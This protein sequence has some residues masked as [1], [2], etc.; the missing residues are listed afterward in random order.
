[1]VVQRPHMAQGRDA[2][3]VFFVH[4]GQWHTVGKTIFNMNPA[5]AIEHF[6]NQYE[7]VKNRKT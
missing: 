6:K 1:M 7:P 3:A 4:R 2:T 5:M